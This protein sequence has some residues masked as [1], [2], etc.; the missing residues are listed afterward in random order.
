MSKSFNTWIYISKG[1]KKEEEWILT[2]MDLM[3][4]IICIES[5][6]QYISVNRVKILKDGNKICRISNIDII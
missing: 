1:K 4:F 3:T 5:E 2:T 6:Q